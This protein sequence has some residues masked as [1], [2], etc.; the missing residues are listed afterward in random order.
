[1][2]NQ[3][4][5]P[6][7]AF[8]VALLLLSLNACKKDD[9]ESGYPDELTVQN[10]EEF[11]DAPQDIVDELERK[12][13]LSLDQHNPHD[14]IP[15]DNSSS[16]QCPNGRDL[17]G[18]IYAYDGTWRDIANV[19]VKVGRYYSYTF[20]NPDSTNY[21]LRVLGGYDSDNKKL[22]VNTNLLNGV[23][24]MDLLLIR[25]HINGT[26]PFT[27]FLQVSAAD[28]DGNKV[29]DID[30]ANLVQ[31]ALLGNITTFP[32][33]NVT[34]YPE[35]YYT[36]WDDNWQSTGAFLNGTF[37]NTSGGKNFYGVKRGDVN[38][39]FNF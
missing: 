26:Q 23:S 18:N 27:T 16:L 4:K 21:K 36:S 32:M 11:V 38:G 39:T 19:R 10:F 13:R 29:V 35:H 1:M 7:G 5:A 33:G 34:F 20:A 28:V 9:P 31:D 12:E 24:A 30:D 3:F 15:P 37:T 2:M 17:I 14:I 25:R 8:L 22:T 6:L